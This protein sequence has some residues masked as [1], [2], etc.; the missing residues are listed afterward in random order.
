MMMELMHL[1]GMIPAAVWNIMHRLHTV[2]HEV[3]LVGG[4][5]R[6]LFLGNTPLDFDLTTSAL[7][8]TVVTLFPKTRTEGILYGTVTVVNAGVSVEVTTMRT[9]ADYRDGRRPEQIDFTNSI[10]EDLR[11]RDFTVNAMAFDGSVLYDL[12]GGTADIRSGIIRTVGNPAARFQEDGLRLLRAVRMSCVLDFTLHL[13]TLDAI[14]AN[15]KMIRNVAPQ[16]IRPELEAILLSRHPDRG[17]AMLARTGLLNGLAFTDQIREEFLC[18]E[19]WAP[20]CRLPLDLAA[21][22]A[23]FCLLIIGKDFSYAEGKADSLTEYMVSLLA[24]YAFPR[25]QIQRTRTMIL[26]INHLPYLSMIDIRRFMRRGGKDHAQIA[27]SFL[28]E[29]AAFLGLN[30]MSAQWRKQVQAVI[31]SGE[32]TDISE[33]AID[34]KDLAVLGIP[35]GPQV[36]AMLEYLLERILCEPELNTTLHLVELV[37]EKMQNED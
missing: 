35:E 25:K 20:L 22:L 11:R 10:L 23:M 24:K 31:E 36:G 34:G 2:G 19:Y 1:K 14:V 6:D 26:E 33:L 15:V 37:C 16:R 9:E 12:F 18:R 21:R 5:V 29:A 27:A 13:R 30:G 3:Y 4:S 17:C 32:C 7:P 8:E 28:S